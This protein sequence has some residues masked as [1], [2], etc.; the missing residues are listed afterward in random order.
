MCYAGFIAQKCVV[1]ILNIISLLHC[2]DSWWCNKRFP[3]FSFLFSL[4]C[5]QSG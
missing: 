4:F 3:L 1:F 2:K 5:F